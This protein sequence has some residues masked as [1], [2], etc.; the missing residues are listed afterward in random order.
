[1]VKNFAKAI[2]SFIYK[3]T[4]KRLKVLSYLSIEDADFMEV[5]KSL[6]GHIH[7]ISELR[8]LWT[9]EGNIYHK[10]FRIMSCEYLRKYCL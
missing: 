8:G 3:N 2:F 9:P 6:K 5:F 7:S 1:M 4:E 10:A